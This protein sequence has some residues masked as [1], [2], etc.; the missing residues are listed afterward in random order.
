MSATSYPY[1]IEGLRRAEDGCWTATLVVYGTPCAV[2]RRFGAWRFTPEDESRYREVAYPYAA[3]LQREVRKIE[4]A[5][6]KSE[7]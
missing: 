5:E 1:T 3:A 6:R 4:R 7:H 2:D